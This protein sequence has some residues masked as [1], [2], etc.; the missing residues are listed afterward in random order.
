M[1]IP[2]MEKNEEYDSRAIVIGSIFSEIRG[3]INDDVDVVFVRRKL[4]RIEAESGEVRIEARFG[5][6][7]EKFEIIQ[8][9]VRKNG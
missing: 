8:L 6:L 3:Q 1:G 4:G 5:Y 9:I 7:E 2:E